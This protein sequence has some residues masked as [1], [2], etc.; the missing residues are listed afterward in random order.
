MT[1]RG[2]GDFC[3][4]IIQFQ[5]I[6]EEYEQCLNTLDRED[7]QYGCPEEST[8]RGRP[9]FVIPVNQLVGLRSKLALNFK[10]GTTKKLAKEMF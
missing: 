8:A 4:L 10:R 9:K 3:S 5:Q 2:K 1:T 6:R 7:T